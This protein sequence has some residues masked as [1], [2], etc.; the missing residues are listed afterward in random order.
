MNT[1]LFILLFFIVGMSITSC[2]S[3]KTNETFENQ[4]E[5]SLDEND[6]VQKSILNNIFDKNHFLLH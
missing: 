5:D 6:K 4:T 3:D 1:K 2:K